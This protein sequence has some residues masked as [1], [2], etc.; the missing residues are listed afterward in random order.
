MGR[1]EV[2]KI[3]GGDPA[4]IYSSLEIRHEMSTLP[5]LLTAPYGS[6]LASNRSDGAR[7]EADSVLTSVPLCVLPM[8]LQIGVWVRGCHPT[9]CFESKFPV[10][11]FFTSVVPLPRHLELAVPVVTA[12][13]LHMCVSPAV[14]FAFDLKFP[15][16]R[17][18]A[19]TTIR[20]RTSP[21]LRAGAKLI[22]TA[23][24][25]ALRCRE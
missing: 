17:K 1:T 7:E 20:T 21:A 5:D 2:E 16:V 6:T 22:D 4:P 14:V 24:A 3:D 15:R 25:F 13:S 23:K 19:L 18:I 9:F 8:P 11:I 10:L 12:C